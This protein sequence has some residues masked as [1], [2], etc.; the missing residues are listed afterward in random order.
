MTHHLAE[1]AHFFNVNLIDIGHFSEQEGMHKLAE[2]LEKKF[3]KINFK[4]IAHKPLWNI[5]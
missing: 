2:I 4:Y 3:P 1:H 5:E